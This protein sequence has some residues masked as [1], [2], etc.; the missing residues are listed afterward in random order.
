VPRWSI[1]HLADA[2]TLAQRADADLKYDDGRTR[3]WLS[4]ADGRVVE[5]E[6]LDEAT[7]TWVAQAPRD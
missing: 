6:R 4:R 3:L 7:G 5:V 2:P 1:T